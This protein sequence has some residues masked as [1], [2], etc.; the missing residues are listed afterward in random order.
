MIQ[1]TKQLP[2]DPTA[3]TDTRPTICHVI[4]AL[5]VGGAEALVDVM[6]RRMSD[7]YRCVVAVLDEVGEIGESLREDGFVIEHLHPSP[8]S[9]VAVLSD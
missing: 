8:V 5:G 7:S 9:I 4:H 3:S 1:A 6:V 2:T